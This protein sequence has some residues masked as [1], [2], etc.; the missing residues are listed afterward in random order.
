MVDLE[1]LDEPEDVALVR[2]LVVRHAAWT[3]SERAA[4]V[5]DAWEAHRDAFVKVMPRDYKRVLL[6][7]ARESAAQ[8]AAQAAVLAPVVAHG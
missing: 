6:Q 1:R 5:L 8:E 4:R 3:G 7:Q 2:D